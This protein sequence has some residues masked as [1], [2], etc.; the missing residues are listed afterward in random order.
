MSDRCVC[1]CVRIANMCL[2]QRSVHIHTRSHHTSQ[3]SLPSL[4]HFPLFNTLHRPSTPPQDLQRQAEAGQL[5]GP[6]PVVAP[7]P[8]PAPPGDMGRG[9]RQRGRARRGAAWQRCVGLC[10]NAEAIGCHS[11]AKAV[12]GRRACGHAEGV[13]Y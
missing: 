10:L 12:A 7:T 3:R 11:Y 2:T 4:H 13:G 9:A 5:P 8:P 1:V 6:A